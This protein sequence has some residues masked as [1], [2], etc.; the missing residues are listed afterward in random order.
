MMSCEGLLTLAQNMY[1]Y[2]CYSPGQLFALAQR[3]M[4]RAF[5]WVPFALLN[6]I[7]EPWSGIGEPSVD[8]VSA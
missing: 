8:L 1:T 5:F 7:L 2:L 4:D 6:R 3:Y